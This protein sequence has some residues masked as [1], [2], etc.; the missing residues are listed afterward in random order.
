[1]K[2]LI[3]LIIGLIG[4]VIIVYFDIQLV[5][6]LLS[7]VPDGSWS[8]LVRA[9]IVFLDIWFTAGLCIL[10]FVLGGYIGI[11]IEEAT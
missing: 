11:A 7:L 9:C 1:M 4:S 2:I 3:G 6:Y 10:P 5:K 8:G